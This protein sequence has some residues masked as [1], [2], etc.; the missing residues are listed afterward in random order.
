MVAQEGRKLRYFFDPI[1]HSRAKDPKRAGETTQTAAFWIGMQNLLA[2]SL[3]IGMGS[4]VLAAL[5]SACTAGIQLF[6]HSEHNHCVRA[7]RVFQ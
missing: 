6:A 2:A 3:Q 5:T 4:R 1:R 7:P